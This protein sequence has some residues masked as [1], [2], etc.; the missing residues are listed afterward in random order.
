MDLHQIVCSKCMSRVAQGAAS[1]PYCGHVFVNTN[2]AGTLPVNT[3]LAGRYTLGACLSI[4]GEGVTYAAIDNQ[5]SRRLVIKEYVP[6]T[7]CAA[8]TTN[9]D[10]LPRPNREVLFKTTRMDFVD[11]YRSLSVLGEQEGLVQVYDLF[12]ANNTAYAVRDADEGT[13]LLAYLQ[14]RQAPL[15]QDESIELLRPI[16]YG[17]EAMHRRGL[18]HRGISP[19]TIFIGNDGH[20]RL[21]GYAT[22]GLRTAD[23]ELKSQLFDGYAAP[24]QYAVAEFDGQYSDV[25]ALGALFYRVMTGKTP[26]SARR[27]SPHDN[28]QTPRSIDSSIPTFV[29]TAIMRAMRLAPEER[30]QSAPELL[31]AV[32]EPSAQVRGFHFTERQIKYLV[33]GAIGLLLVM[34]LSIWAMLSATLPKKKP[35]S[36]SV[37]A[38]SP[39]SSAPSVVQ[40]AYPVPSLLGKQYTEVQQNAEYSQ[41]FLFEIVE[42]YSSDYRKGEIMRQSPDSNTKVAAGTTIKV[43]VSL[44]AQTAVMP[45]VVGLSVGDA[46][47]LLDPLKIKYTVIELDNDG[48]Y[49]ENVIAK[50]DTEVGTE[51]NVSKQQVVLFVAKASTGTYV[52]DGGSGAGGVPGTTPG[53]TPGTA[54]T[55]GADGD[56]LNERVD[57][58]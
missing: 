53:I 22:L 38:S 48:R 1:C 12:E 54:V 3:L 11:L 43:T 27:R 25:Y 34:L 26:T 15:T 46:K 16:V 28:L 31:E 5:L 42:E 58:D 19:E 32:T 23:S 8:R 39:V 37:S 14:R 13:P 2:P 29:S 35:V 33:V 6:I 21:S 36:S 30:I 18:L 17:V 10:V 9:G 40:Q 20:A 52:P 4:D 41:K 7:I 56:R 57:D 49:Q 50:T 45:S 55:P 51:L 44:G 47:M 24:E